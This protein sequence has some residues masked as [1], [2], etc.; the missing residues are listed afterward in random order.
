MLGSPS[1]R[2]DGMLGAPLVPNIGTVWEENVL[3]QDLPP[4]PLHPQLRKR[5]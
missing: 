3:L 1:A 4:P 5:W 2:H